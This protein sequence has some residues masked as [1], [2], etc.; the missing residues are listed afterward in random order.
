MTDARWLQAFWGDHAA[1]CPGCAATTT[2]LDIIKAFESVP[3][4]D[5]WRRGCLLGH[6]RTI[7]RFA[8]EACAAARH[9]TYMGAVDPEEVLTLSAFLAG[10][11]FA[12][13]VLF[14]ALSGT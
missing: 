1:A 10:M 2:L 13:D 11:P 7:P 8:L 6:P 9:L 5:L 4:G 14:L 3:L 12:S